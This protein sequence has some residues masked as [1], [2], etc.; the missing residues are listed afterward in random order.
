MR[1]VSLPEKL[2]AIH[3]IAAPTMTRVLWTLVM[4]MTPMLSPWV[5]V[6]TDPKHPKTMVDSPSPRRERWRPGS[7]VRSRPTRLEVKFCRG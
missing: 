5:V 7:F 3:M 2:R 4:A 6:G 1:A